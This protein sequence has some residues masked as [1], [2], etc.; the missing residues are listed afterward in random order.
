MK[1]VL[2]KKAFLFRRKGKVYCVLQHKT[3]ITCV[4]FVFFHR[5]GAENRI[6][7]SSPVLILPVGKDGLWDSVCPGGT[8]GRMKN[9]IALSQGNVSYHTQAKWKGRGRYASVWVCVNK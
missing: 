9:D 6:P 3:M 4:I 5:G 1:N 8:V 2:T 7:W